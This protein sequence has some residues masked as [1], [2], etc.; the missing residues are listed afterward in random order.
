MC[1]KSL[2]FAASRGTEALKEAWLILSKPMQK[3]L[4]A[5]KDTLKDT[6][7]HADR[8]RLIIDTSTGLSEEEKTELARAEAEGKL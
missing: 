2:S 7:A 5:F 6:A 3:E 8:D 4:A 1:R